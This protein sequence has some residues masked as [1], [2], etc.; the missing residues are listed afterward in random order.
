M[1]WQIKWNEDSDEIGEQEDDWEPAEEM[2]GRSG[3]YKQLDEGGE[4]GGS[5]KKKGGFMF[6]M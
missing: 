6:L 1:K 3:V 2:T 5:A 4:G